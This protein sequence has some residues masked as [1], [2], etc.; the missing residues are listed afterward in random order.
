MNKDTFLKELRE[1]LSGLPIQEIDKTIEYYSEMIDDAVEDGENES[2]AVKTFGSV[3]EIANKIIDEIPI[4]T[5]VANFKKHKF[6]AAA[7]VLILL[8]SP[9][10]VPLA[11]AFIAVII[12]VYLTI[13]TVIA[14]I[15]ITAAAFAVSAVGAIALIIAMTFSAQPLKILFAAGILLFG[16]GSAILTFYLAILFTKLLIKLTAYITRKF[17]KLFVKQGRVENE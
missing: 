2:D 1:S 13:W 7:I 6:S 17:K 8:A 10:W 14:V 12:S 16:A 5:L 4:H 11:A 9:V 15:F 3:Q